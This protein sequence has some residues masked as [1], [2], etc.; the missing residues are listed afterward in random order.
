MP[1]Q[2]REKEM[3]SNQQMHQ[4]KPC[5]KQKDA[6][7]INYQVPQNIR[8][9]ILSILRQEKCI[10]PETIQQEMLQELKGMQENKQVTFVSLSNRSYLTPNS[11]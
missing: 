11:E 8:L 3:R 5:L 1:F 6:F 7:A 10:Y 9:T 4:Q 2:L